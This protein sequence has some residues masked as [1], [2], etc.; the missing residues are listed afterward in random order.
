MRYKEVKPKYSTYLPTP[1]L[2][3]V[4]RIR[5]RYKEETT[6]TISSHHKYRDFARQK[7]SS[8]SAV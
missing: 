6:N 3:H 2:R 7:I 8:S 5:L 1:P 4:R